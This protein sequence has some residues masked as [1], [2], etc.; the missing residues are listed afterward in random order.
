M[1]VE[2][3]AEGEVEGLWGDPS[4]PQR[5]NDNSGLECKLPYHPTLPVPFPLRTIIYLSSADVIDF[6]SLISLLP[7]AQRLLG[8][9][10]VLWSRTLCDVCNRGELQ[11]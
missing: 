11:S 10:N 5:P 1:E 9:I 6:L 4:S 7:I 8:I 3:E 2:V